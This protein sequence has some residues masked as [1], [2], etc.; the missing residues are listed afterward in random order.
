MALT[1]C[2]KLAV[3]PAHAGVQWGEIK[4]INGFWIPTCAGMTDF[5]VSHNF[6]H[7]VKTQLIAAS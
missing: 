2:Q 5:E 7:P 6:Q 1:G 4:K 3:T